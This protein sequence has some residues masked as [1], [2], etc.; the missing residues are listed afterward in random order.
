[1]PSRG[2]APCGRYRR[3]EHEELSQG[4]PSS[5]GNTSPTRRV[6]SAQQRDQSGRFIFAP[7]CSGSCRWQIDALGKHFRT[8]MQVDSMTFECAAISRT[9]IEVNTAAVNLGGRNWQ[10]NQRGQ[11]W[12]YVD[13]LDRQ[14]LL[15]AYDT[16]S[17]KENRNLSVIVPR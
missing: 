4:L 12:Q 3:G 13:G 7:S 10:L 9:G 1:T 16:R 5:E 17:I 14:R 2:V 6:A 8:L 15:E 11:G